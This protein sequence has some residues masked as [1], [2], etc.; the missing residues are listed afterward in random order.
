MPGF[1]PL[2]RNLRTVIIGSENMAHHVIDTTDS[3][4]AICGL[5]APTL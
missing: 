4:E 2:T 3:G 5:F 1:I